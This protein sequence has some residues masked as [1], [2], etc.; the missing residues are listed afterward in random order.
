[1]RGVHRVM[2]IGFD[3]FFKNFFNLMRIVIV[4]RCG[5]QGVAYQRDRL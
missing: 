5:T 2:Q 1:M 3:A 4:H